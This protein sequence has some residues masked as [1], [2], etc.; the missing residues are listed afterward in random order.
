MPE[1]LVNTI[2]FY[3]VLHLIP[4]DM[5][6]NVD[7]KKLIQGCLDMSNRSKDNLKKKLCINHRKAQYNYAIQGVIDG[8]FEHG[9]ATR[10][11]NKLKEIKP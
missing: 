9:Y 4:S 10:R 2:E 7:G 8:K 1:N 5:A 3:C 11:W 6:L